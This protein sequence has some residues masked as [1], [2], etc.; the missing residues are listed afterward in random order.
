M[1]DLQRKQ[2]YFL[3]LKLTDEQVVGSSYLSRP[4]VCIHIRATDGPGKLS[5]T[6]S[7]LENLFGETQ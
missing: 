6:K 2:S 5:Y 4:I 1:Q 7:N 3:K